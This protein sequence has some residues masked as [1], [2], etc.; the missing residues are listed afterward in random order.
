MK[1]II[2]PTDFSESAEKAMYYALD[3]ALVFDAE[4]HLY[5]GYQMPHSRADVMM[6]VM[7]ILK[8]DA[9]EG[10]KI[11]LDKLSENTKYSKLKISSEIRL[12]DVSLLIEDK[13]ANEEFDLL[14]M[15]TTGASGLKKVV[16]STASHV[17]KNSKIPVITVPFGCKIPCSS[18]EN[19][20][21]ALDLVDINNQKA[22][23]FFRTF[24]VKLGSKVTFVNVNKREREIA[25]IN[26]KANEKIKSYFGFDYSFK[27]VEG[28]E[29]SSGIEKFIE[30]NS[31]NIM[32]MVDRKDTFF[33]RLFNQSITQQMSYKSDVPLLILKDK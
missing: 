26:R 15:G 33:E 30:E 18:T 4:F 3:L 19:I 9:E 7:D 31:I 27:I 5:H 32:T 16:G 6:S 14:V 23:D 12:G 22:L 28:T 25:E 13:I 20:G 10:M 29:I 17:I 1:K 2:F 24:V 21:F 8:K 11:T